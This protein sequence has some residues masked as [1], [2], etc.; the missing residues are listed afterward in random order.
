MK[1]L[2]KIQP[3]ATNRPSKMLADTCNS[4]KTLQNSPTG[5]YITCFTVKLLKPSKCPKAPLLLSPHSHGCQYSNSLKN[6]STMESTT[7]SHIYPPST[8]LKQTNLLPRNTKALCNKCCMASVNHNRPLSTL[9]NKGFDTVLPAYPH[10]KYTLH[11]P[12][13]PHT[14][15][16]K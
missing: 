14:K 13:L 2:H 15:L 10:S 4:I 11:C 12:T 16:T 3:D 5:T 1:N 8:A 9:H 6:Q 7:I